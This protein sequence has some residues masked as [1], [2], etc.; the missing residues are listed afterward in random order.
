M[1]LCIIIN[2]LFNVLLLSLK[3]DGRKTL[4]EN[5]ADN[6]GLDIAFLVR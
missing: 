4:E 2:L 5:I 6:V 1:Y 3:V